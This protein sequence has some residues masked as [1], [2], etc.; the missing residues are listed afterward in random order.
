MVFWS[1]RGVHLSPVFR[2]SQK[3]SHVGVLTSVFSLIFS[4]ATI[5]FQT[6]KCFQVLDEMCKDEF[7]TY[8]DEI[9]TLG[10]DTVH[11]T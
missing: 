10:H 1:R 4:F 3:G 8:M 6:Q 2:C 11:L 5:G 7:M 9:M